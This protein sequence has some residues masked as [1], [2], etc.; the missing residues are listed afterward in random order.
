[1]PWGLKGAAR[2][3][4]ERLIN[5]VDIGWLYSVALNLFQEEEN[6]TKQKICVLITWPMS[7]IL[8]MDGYTVNNSIYRSAFKPNHWLKR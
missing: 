6:I 4:Y 3:A 8:R 2:E 7:S 1:M 5:G